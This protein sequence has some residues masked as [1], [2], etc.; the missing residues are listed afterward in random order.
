MANITHE[1]GFKC[2][3]IVVFK[4]M[5]STPREFIGKY[6]TIYDTSPNLCYIRL[7][8]GKKIGGFYHYRFELVGMSLKDK[9]FV[10]G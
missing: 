1:H 4:N 6:G 3:D 2:G 10:Y 9:R 8:S 5:D 7:D